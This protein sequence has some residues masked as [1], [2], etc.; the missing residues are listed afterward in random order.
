[1]VCVQR[2]V[3]LAGVRLGAVDADAHAFD[4]HVRDRWH[5][6]V[7]ADEGRLGELQAVAVELAGLEH[8][9]GLRHVRPG[10]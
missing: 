3:G 8:H 7:E 6:R 9:V 4:R 1:M 10:G 2:R 5:R